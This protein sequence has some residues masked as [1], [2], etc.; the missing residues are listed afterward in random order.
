M[1]QVRFGDERK[2]LEKRVDRSTL[3]P[4]ETYSMVERTC[5]ESHGL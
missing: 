2:R 3:A 1:N 5:L 4:V